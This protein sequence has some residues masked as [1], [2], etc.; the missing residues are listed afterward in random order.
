MEVTTKMNTH[1]FD[2]DDSA[3]SFTFITTITLFCSK[4][5]ERVNAQ[6]W[7]YFLGVFKE[8]LTGQSDIIISGKRFFEFL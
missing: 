3:L 1:T 7:E 4:L 8:I 2:I 5:V 6:R